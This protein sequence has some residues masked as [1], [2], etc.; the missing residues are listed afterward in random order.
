MNFKYLMPLSFVAVTGCIVPNETLYTNSYSS[1]STTTY[2]DDSWDDTYHSHDAFEE[3]DAFG[4]FF[5]DDFFGDMDRD[6]KLRKEKQRLAK[7]QKK[8]DR[9]LK[10]QKA[11]LELQLLRQKND[12]AD[13]MRKQQELLRQAERRRQDDANRR[14][15]RQ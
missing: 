12:H 11:E 15:E 13:V 4:D 8:Q 1:R 3:P 14:L 5:S 9:E 7:R 2:Y 6:R 10:C